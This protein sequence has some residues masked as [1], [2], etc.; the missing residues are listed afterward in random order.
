M[1]KRIG[2]GPRRHYEIT[3]GLAKGYG[4][5][6]VVHSVDDAKAAHALWMLKRM[7]NP[8]PKDRDFLTGSFTKSTVGYGWPPN[9]DSTGGTGDEPCVLFAG[10]V[11][12][13][14]GT[15]LSDE[16]VGK[17]LDDLASSVGEALGQ[18]RVYVSYRDDAWVLEKQG[19]ETP[20]GK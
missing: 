14:Y 13:L 15:H 1:Y 2:I 10:D 18:T 3:F 6:A 7:D 17:I 12:V 8:D 16:Q 19:G 20:N 11:S 9:G 4:E 5:N